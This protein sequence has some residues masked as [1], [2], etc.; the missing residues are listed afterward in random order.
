MSALQ[1]FNKR[2]S[3]LDILFLDYLESNNIILL[4]VLMSFVS[5]I[6]LPDKIEAKFLMYI[7]FSCI[8]LLNYLFSPF[9]AFAIYFCFLHS[10]R[11]I[12]VISKSFNLLSSNGDEFNF[13][14]FGVF[15]SFYRHA[16]LL[17]II[18]SSIFIACIYVGSY[19]L[20]IDDSFL[21]IIFPGLAALAV[22]HLIL[23]SIY[24]K[25]A[26]ESI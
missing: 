22:P 8:V 14:I 1:I 7:E 18:S 16:A 5:S 17:T 15:V 23:E 10:M 6:Y 21:K 13:T 20:Q 19:I 24:D 4:L 11:H 25:A 9:E 3:F 2:H 12:V 26:I